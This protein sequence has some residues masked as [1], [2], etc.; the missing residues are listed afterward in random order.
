MLRAVIFCAAL[1]LIGVAALTVFSLSGNATSAVR[2]AA[3]GMGAPLSD[4]PRTEVF[5]VEPGMTARD[6]GEALES[7]ELIRSALA[8][9]LMSEQQGVGGQ[10]AA[11]DYE[12][13]PSM[14]TEQVLSILVR[15]EVKRG[16]RVTVIE[17]WRAEEI[18]H[19]LEVMQ[20]A[21]P[22]E[23]LRLVRDPPAESVPDGLRLTTDGAEGYLFPSTYEWDDKSG[24][25]GFVGQLLTQFDDQVHSQLRAKIRAQGLSLQQALILASIVEREAARADE[26]PIIASVYHNRL[27]ASMPLQAD[28]TVQYAV[29]NARPEE[30]AREGFWLPLA[31][32]DLRLESD[33]NTYFIEGL[34]AGPICN[35]GL[36]S[37]LAVAEPAETDFLYFVAR[38]DGTHAFARTED[39]HFANIRKYQP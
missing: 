31:L 11:G 39:E 12:I 20:L 29:A 3:G 37:I 26:R 30:A 33:Y 35:P 15:G 24:V 6:I 23:F 28:P 34:P 13:S 8:F 1:I 9:R 17:G 19:Q 36:D 25:E 32:A 2:G 22:G 14:S 7:R 18:A 5:T 21:D 16:S 27:K 10:L 38:G 4:D